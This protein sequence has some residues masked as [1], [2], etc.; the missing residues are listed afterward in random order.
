MAYPH[1]HAHTLDSLVGELPS[2]SP[3]GV[4]LCRGPSAPSLSGLF[5]CTLV[6]DPK[7]TLK[8]SLF[9]R[10]AKSESKD[11]AYHIP[12]ATR[13]TFDLASVYEC[14]CTCMMFPAFPVAEQSPGKPPSQPRLPPAL[15]T[16]CFQNSHGWAQG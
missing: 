12:P 2:R 16:L 10:A 11:L 5:L 4:F 3:W 13:L 14:T 6:T 15:C 7:L 9:V 1:A 8:P